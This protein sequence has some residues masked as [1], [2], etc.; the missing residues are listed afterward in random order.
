MPESK[1][2]RI[3]V[4]TPSWNRA[5]YLTRVWAGLCKQSYADF[6][7]IVAN[8]G[9]NDETI[10]VVSELAAKSRFQMTLINASVRVGKSCMDNVMV[11]A[12]QGEF[13]IWCDSDDVLEPDALKVLIEAWDE[14]PSDMRSGYMGV[15][16][17]AFTEEGILGREMPAGADGWTWNRIYEQLRSDLVILARKDLLLSNPFLEVDYLI[18]E[19]S[20]WNIIGV[21]RSRFID[22][23]LKRVF[24]NQ[25]LALSFSGKMQY[26][27]GRA[28]ALARNYPYVKERLGLMGELVRGMNYIRYCAH[29]DVPFLTAAR[30]WTGGVVSLLTLALVAVP[31]AFLVIR[32]RLRGAVEKTHIPFEQAKRQVEITRRMWPGDGA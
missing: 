21:R 18:P 27:R 23:P 32:D 7:W 19:T 25:P 24:Y 20:V 31:A 4:V 1:Q 17:R 3:S 5:T 11:R 15:S 10:G 12:A 8:D 22:K 14:L 30:L 9:S 13:V 29:G 16:A 2:P 26:N 28:Y 6:E